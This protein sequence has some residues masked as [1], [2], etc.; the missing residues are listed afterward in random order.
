MTPAN[1]V[2]EC[3]DAGQRRTKYTSE[4]SETFFAAQNG[5]PRCF[6]SLNDLNVWL[7]KLPEYDHLRSSWRNETSVVGFF[8]FFLAFLNAQVPQGSGLQMNHQIHGLARPMDL[9]MLSY[10]YYDATTLS[11]SHVTF[12]RSTTCEVCG[13]SLAGFWKY[14]VLYSIGKLGVPNIFFILWYVYSICIWYPYMVSIYY[15]IYMCVI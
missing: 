4:R 13:M 14:R 15:D 10:S 8:P 9:A 2:E 5:L 1:S 3:G 12:K 6:G 7:K 11:E